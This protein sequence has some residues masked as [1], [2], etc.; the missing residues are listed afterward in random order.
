MATAVMTR[1]PPQARRLAPQLFEP[2]LESE[3]S[4]L[5]EAILGVWEDLTDAACA[6]CPV[7]GGTLVPEACLDCDSELY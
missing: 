7:C 6:E 2:E 4:T 5:E 3:G 1:Q